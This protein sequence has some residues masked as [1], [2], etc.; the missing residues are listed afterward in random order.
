MV[1]SN[2]ALRA[3]LEW[4]LCP[5]SNGLENAAEGLNNIGFGVFGS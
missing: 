3:T 2:V 5:G 1:H 4:R